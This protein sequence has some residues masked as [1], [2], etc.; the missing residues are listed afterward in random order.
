MG[1]KTCAL[2]KKVHGMSACLYSSCKILKKL[3]AC[4]FLG[5]VWNKWLLHNATYSATLHTVQQVSTK[6]RLSE[7]L[8]Q[9]A[10]KHDKT[11]DEIKQLASDVASIKKAVEELLKKA[12][13]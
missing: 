11:S 8:H 2:W 5:L 9:L 13:G 10:V 3:P 1:L 4:T 7:Q 6:E 12:S